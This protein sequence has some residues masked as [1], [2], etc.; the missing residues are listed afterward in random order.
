MKYLPRDS[1]EYLSAL[2]NLHSLDFVHSIAEPITEEGFHTRF[3]A[4]REA[5][6]EL[7]LQFTLTSSNMFV[8]LI[9][10]F[11]NVTTVRLGPFSLNL[12][13][14]PVLPLSRPLRGKV[15]IYPLGL[16]SE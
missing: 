4:F 15:P 10:Y 1:G 8:T 16:D 11:P 5:P 2:C 9:D 7:S 12:D 6:T 14:V 13:E 3:S